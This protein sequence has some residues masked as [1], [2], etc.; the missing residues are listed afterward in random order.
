MTIYRGGGAV[1]EARGGQI[2]SIELIRNSI[3]KPADRLD[4]PYP[5]ADKLGRSYPYGTDRH[6]RTYP[7]VD[8]YPLPYLS[9][10]HTYPHSFLSV[11]CPYPLTSLSTF[12]PIRSRSY[13]Q[14]YL[15][16]SHLYPIPLLSKIIP[17]F[18]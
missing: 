15:S 14:P 18:P 7:Q 9:E 11:P 12:V 8:P 16:K 5:Y 4:R 10:I 6:E 1:W 2:G 17:I 3:Q 13:P